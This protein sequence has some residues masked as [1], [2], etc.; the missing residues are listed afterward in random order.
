[1]ANTVRLKR[2]AV[3]GKAPTTSDLSLGELA[4]NTY[5]GKLYTKKDNGT[6]SIVEVGGGGSVGLNDVTDVTI[7]SPADDQFLRYTGTAWVNETVTIPASADIQ[8]F[9]SSG[10][11]TKPSN[12][13]L[14]RV[15]AVGGGGGGGS[16]AKVI[17]AYGSV[18]SPGG[19]GGGAGGVRHEVIFEAS[20]LG[21]TETVTVGSGGTGGTGVTANLTT[22]SQGSD[23]GSSSFGSHVIALGGKKGGGGTTVETPGGAPWRI[24]V[25]LD[26]PAI[27]A[28]GGDGG[29]G[30]VAGDPGEDSLYGPGGGGGGGGI[31]ASDN[32]VYGPGTGGVGVASK[33][34]QT[35]WLQ[36]FFSTR[37]SVNTD[38][39]TWFGGG[40]GSAVVSSSGNAGGDGGANG[41]GGSGGGATRNGT[42]SGAGGD[43]GDGIVIVYTYF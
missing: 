12:A 15:I 41:G 34:S 24:P 11:W 29:S 13:K 39:A 28:A 2:S 14:V 37:T 6:E 31:R 35:V 5:D 42:S 1:M 8:T 18:Y 26:G 3:Q 25:Y 38:G 43:G 20:N 10:T 27:N 16:G 32:F 4:L 19:G 30:S 9:T 23:G 21:S 36:S 33:L 17:T 40:G 22:G 7:S